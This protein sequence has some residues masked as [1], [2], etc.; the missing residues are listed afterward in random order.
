MR[1]AVKFLKANRDDGGTELGV[2]LEQALDRDRGANTPSRHVLILTDAE[3]TDA[4]RILRLADAE[5]AKPNRRRISV[6]C[7]DAAPNAA[8]ASELAE[9]GG[10]VSRFLTSDPEEDD[11]AT[12]LDEVLADWS[13]PVLTGLT[14]EVNRSGAEA[15][16]RHG[17]G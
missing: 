15:A 9:R 8:L 4:G 3:V 10:G 12:A 5:S 1:D 17:G 13:A 16:G 2:A 14:L 6:L 7:I 11:V